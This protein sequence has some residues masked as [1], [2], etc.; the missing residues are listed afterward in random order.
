MPKPAPTKHK[1]EWQFVAF[2]TR[3]WWGRDRLDTFR[4]V[5][6][7]PCKK[8]EHGIVEKWEPLK[9]KRRKRK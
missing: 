4:V 1:H 6:S 3:V 9:R 5:R 2:P 7:C 8:T